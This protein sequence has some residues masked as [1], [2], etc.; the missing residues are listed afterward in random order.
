ME[1]KQENRS[2]QKKGFFSKFVENLDKKMKEKST[3]S[4][5][6]CGGGGK[7]EDKKSC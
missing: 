3:H 7:K 6:C 2:A 1:N 5:C 4:C